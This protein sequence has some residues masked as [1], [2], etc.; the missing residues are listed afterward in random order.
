[1]KYLKNNLIVA[2][3]AVILLTATFAESYD[4]KLNI[5]SKNIQWEESGVPGA[6]FGLLWGSVKDK[7]ATWLVRIAPGAAFPVH[8]HTNDYWGISLQGNWV[9]IGPK[10]K[11]LNVTEG[12]YAF[13][14]AGEWHADRCDGTEDCIVLLDFN[15][16][17]DAFFP[18]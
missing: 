13:Q 12:S 5:D 6:Q 18:E 14:A 11:E 15:G 2:T 3:A 4:N 7:D 16:K 17:R 10:G 8:A 9:H 1:M